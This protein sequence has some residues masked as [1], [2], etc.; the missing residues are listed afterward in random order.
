VRAV[1]DEHKQP[2]HR[3]LNLK[4]GDT[5][6]LDVPPDAPVTLKCG[7]VDLSQGKVGRMGQSL[8]VRVDRA[9]A[10]AMQQAIMKI[11]GRS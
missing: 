6:M 9:I 2:L 11:G 10:P 4:V 8:A 1:L 7:A 3:V 5:L